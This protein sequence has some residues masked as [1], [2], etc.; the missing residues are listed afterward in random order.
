MKRLANLGFAAVLFAS[1]MPCGAWGPDGHSIVG[2]I[3][4][5]RLDGRARAEVQ[6]LL[7]PGHSLASEGAWA[8]DVRAQRPETFNWHFVDIPLAEA[9]YRAARDCRATPKGDCIVGE[10][11]R[12]RQA[13]RCGGN[14]ERREALRWA[15]HLVADLHQPLHTIAEEQG[16]NTVPLEVAIA[17]LRC[18]R[19]TPSRSAQ[20]LHWLWD[21]SLIAASAWSWGAYVR[22]LEDGWLVSDEAR[23]AAGGNV[24]DWTNETHAVAREVWSWT[25]ADRSIGDDY[26]RKA[27]PVL[28]RQLGRAGLRLAVFLNDAF[29]GSCRARGERARS[30]N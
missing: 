2:E 16:G 23:A 20:N 4:Q 10:L 13:L 17:G 21:G 6:R 22:R 15:I 11:Q 8:D 25:P 19:C 3:A 7:G 27:L 24:I 28:D 29:A 9:S 30:R 14:D 12:A 1:A 26:Y 18:P 5:R